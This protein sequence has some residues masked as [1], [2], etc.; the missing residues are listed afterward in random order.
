MHRVRLGGRIGT[1]R[2]HRPGLPPVP[3]SRLRQA[4]QRAECWLSEPDTVPQRRH[5]PRG[6]L[7]LWRS[8]YKLALRDLP[9]MFLIR[10][11]VFSHEAVRDWETKLA[12]GLAES[13]RRRRRGKAGCSSYADESVP[14]THR[15]AMGV[16]SGIE[17]E[18]RP[19]EAD[20]QEYIERGS[21]FLDVRLAR[22]SWIICRVAQCATEERRSDADLA[23][24]DDLG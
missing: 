2:A 20:R 1:E 12:P 22:F 16:R 13:F 19:L 24:H 5:R 14:R 8:R 10:G 21:I 3:L 6:A 7:V 4:V 17:D 15:P 23:G 18:G 9:E 11:L